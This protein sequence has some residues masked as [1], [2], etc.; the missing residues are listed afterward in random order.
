MELLAKVQEDLVD[1][2]DSTDLA[3]LAHSTTNQVRLFRE[4]AGAV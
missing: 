3:D 4:L 2:G 1:L